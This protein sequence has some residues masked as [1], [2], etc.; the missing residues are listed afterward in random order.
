MVDGNR[1]R[2]LIVD[3][4]DALMK[5]LPLTTKKLPYDYV[6]ESTVAEAVKNM[7]ADRPSVAII[8]Y[9]I[10]GI[11][12]GVQ[13]V[14]AA[15]AMGIKVIM[16]S[17]NAKVAEKAKE[18]EVPFVEKGVGY[19][20]KLIEQISQTLRHTDRKQASPGR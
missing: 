6:G 7:K 12:D 1:N 16:V 13:V 15:N 14:E 5:V 3:D 9:N 11:G 4:T 19:V 20:P 17:G 2:I 10:G 8:D 18:L